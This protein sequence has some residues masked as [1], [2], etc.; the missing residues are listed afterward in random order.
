[1][2]QEVEESLFKVM[3]DETKDQRKWNEPNLTK[4]GSLF[5]KQFGDLLLYENIIGIQQK[6]EG[7]E[8]DS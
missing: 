1:M 5:T 4:E 6:E 2:D 3:R 7:S 8:N